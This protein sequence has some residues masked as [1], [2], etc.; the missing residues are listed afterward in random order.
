MSRAL[1]KAEGEIRDIRLRLGLTQ[2]RFAALIGV[3]PETYRT[4][5]SGRRPVPDRCIDKAR[6]L[7]VTHDPDRRMSLQELATTLGV[8]VRTLRDAA[9]SGR[10]EVVYDNRVVF[11]NLVPR[12]TLAAG[13]RFMERYYRRSYSRFSPRPD[14]PQRW[15]VPEDF[16]SRV[17]MIRRQ[18]GLTQTGLAQRIGAATKA[19]VY[20]WESAKR[21]PSP[22]FWKRIVELLD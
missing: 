5:D 17:V 9:R 19:V 4:W 11:R 20:Q 15:N 12:A 13:R 22:I 1:R 2:P 21:R 7:A 6:A 18:L 8:H 16:A 10:L 3:S 14:A